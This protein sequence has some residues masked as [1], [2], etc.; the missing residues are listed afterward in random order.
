VENNPNIA[1]KVLF[2][3]MSSPPL[4]RPC[5]ARTMD[6]Y[7]S[8]LFFTMDISKKSMVVVTCLLTETFCNGPHSRFLQRYVKRCMLTCTE[9]SKSFM[10]KPRKQFSNREHISSDGDGIYGHIYRHQFM[11]DQLAVACC[12]LLQVWIMHAERISLQDLSMEMMGFCHN[13]QSQVKKDTYRRERSYEKT[14]LRTEVDVVM[15]VVKVLES[16]D[17][18]HLS[19]DL[20]TKIVSRDVSQ[21]MTTLEQLPA[22]W[23]KKQ[24]GD[25]G[26]YYIDHNTQKTQW[27]SPNKN[28]AEKKDAIFDQ[29]AHVT[30]VCESSEFSFNTMA[31][32]PSAVP[33]GWML[34][35]LKEG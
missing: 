24:N 15:E 13:C 27:E 31:T 29:M 32:M 9:M 26:W 3:L 17:D 21:L 20:S 28:S 8:T 33:H 18:L 30:R 16:D 5:P 14:K 11:L 1:V 12:Q 19:V 10:L 4:G 23:E 35:A 34:P 6:D 7:L 25:G 22:G 2:K